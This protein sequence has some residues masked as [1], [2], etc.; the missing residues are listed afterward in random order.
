[1]CILVVLNTL[2]QN[3]ALFLFISIIREKFYTSD[4]GFSIRGPYASQRS[5]PCAG[6]L[7][8]A[9]LCQLNLPVC[10]TPQQVFVAE[11]FH[12]QKVPHQPPMFL[13][14]YSPGNCAD[15][16]SHFNSPL[17]MNITPFMSTVLFYHFLKGATITL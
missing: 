9:V 6:H 3:G 2:S 8:I 13:R 12:R 11:D 7:A 1:M 15:H 17:L 5:A 16:L 10:N 14:R 4:D